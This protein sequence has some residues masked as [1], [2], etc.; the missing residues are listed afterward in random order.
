MVKQLFKEWEEFMLF[1]CLYYHSFWCCSGA[2]GGGGGGMGNGL[3]MAGESSLS[4]I[5]AL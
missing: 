2:G 4:L 5:K 3:K 1:V